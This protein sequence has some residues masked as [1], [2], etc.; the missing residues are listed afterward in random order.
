[1]VSDVFKKVIAVKP[2]DPKEK[3][4]LY[5]WRMLE[6]KGVLDEKLVAHVWG[7][8][9]EDREHWRV[10][11]MPLVSPCLE[12]QA[13]SFPVNVNV[14]SN[15][16]AFRASGVGQYFFPFCQIFKWWSSS[17]F[18]PSAG[19]TVHSVGR[20]KILIR[21]DSSAL[22]RFCYVLYLRRCVLRYF[23]MSLLVCWGL[24]SWREFSTFPTQQRR[25]NLCLYGV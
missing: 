8:L 5:L 23:Y 4:S 12:Q 20:R 14:M 17:S 18:F 3:E 22:Y 19:R 13:V 24:C 25:G 7:P 1:M 2:Y 9:F 15:K 10:L 21:R 11:I 6:S 16:W